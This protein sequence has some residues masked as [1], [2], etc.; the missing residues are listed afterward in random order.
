MCFRVFEP[1]TSNPMSADSQHRHSDTEDKPTQTYREHRAKITNYGLKLS[2]QKALL[3]KLMEGKY[4]QRKLMRHPFILCWVSKL[5]MFSVNLYDFMV[6][7]ITLPFRPALW[8]CRCFGCYHSL[9]VSLIIL[10]SRTRNV[11]HSDFP[12]V[13][14]NTYMC[15]FVCVYVCIYF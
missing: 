7:W 4:T 11:C 2:T 1:V 14:T 8:V 10:A 13:Y 6:Y 5:Y 12:I 9:S 3:L 15:V